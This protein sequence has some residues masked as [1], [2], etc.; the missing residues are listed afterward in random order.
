MMTTMGRLSPFSED[1]LKLPPQL[2]ELPPTIGGVRLSWRARRMFA[3]PSSFL[4]IMARRLAGVAMRRGV[5]SNPVLSLPAAASAGMRG[6]V[7][8]STP[9]RRPLPGFVS[10]A[11][12]GVRDIYALAR[13]AEARRPERMGEADIVEA[14][15]L[16]SRWQSR[17]ECAERRIAELERRLAGSEM[18]ALDLRSRLVCLHGKLATSTAT[19]RYQILTHALENGVPGPAFDRASTP[20][21]IR[22]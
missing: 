14:R 4:R 12:R 5:P 18:A 21:G 10:R 9:Q 7:P 20:G 11:V 8:A 19:A 17:A 13:H 1:L 6:R 3:S 2:L 22:V 16:A 15:L